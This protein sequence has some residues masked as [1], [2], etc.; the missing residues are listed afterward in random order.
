MA[1]LRRLGQSGFVRSVAVLAGGTAAGQGL[2]IL[3]APLLTRLYGPESFGYLGVYMAVLAVLVTVASLR[4]QV[5][6]P[7]PERSEGA[8]NLVALSLAVLLAVTALVALLLA[9]FGPVFARLLGAEGL[10]P[11]W[12][13][14]P[15]GLLGAGVYQVLNYWSIR[16][17]AFG[18]LART[19][20][21]QAL[22]TVAAQLGLGLVTGGAFGLLAGDALGRAAGSGTLL[23]LARARPDWQWRQ[24]SRR[25]LAEI[26]RRYRRFPLLSSGSALL[27]SL[28]LQ[29]ALLLATILY[30][31]VVTGHFALTQRIVGVPM[32]LIGTA[33]SQVYLA[34]A[35][36]QRRRQRE[37]LK[38]LYLKSSLRLFLVGLAPITLLALAGP[39]LFAFVFG[40]EWLE[41]G[42]YA[43]IL[44]P[45]FLAQFVV[46]PLSQTLNVLERQGLQLGWDTA[47]LLLVLGAFVLGQRLSLPPVQTF[48]LYS[49]AGTL[50]YLA[51]FALSYWALGEGGR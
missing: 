51:L 37:G 2:A 21:T 24:V 28:G 3:A 49:A 12:W 4:Y 18:A 22:G 45:M 26:A 40:S 23:R 33:V 48:I 19:K 36:K 34:E 8:M 9:L 46:V 35:A 14:L 15:L 16:T 50:A 47:R 29:L 11:Y 6:I 13:L 39:P 32:T 30:T 41:A 43:R 31:P 1:R 38:R 17:E 27:N 20:L 5:A 25:S 44:A 7:L 10:A 42:R